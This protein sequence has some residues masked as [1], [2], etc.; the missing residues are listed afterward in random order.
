[1]LETLKVTMKSI[2]IKQTNKSPEINFNYD[3]GEL[4]IT[5][6]S[7]VQNSYEFYT[8]LLEWIDD[9]VRAPKAK[10]TKVFIKVVY[11]TTD[12]SGFFIKILKRLEQLAMANHLVMV[13]WYYE[14]GDVDMRETIHMFRSLVPQLNLESV[15]VKEVL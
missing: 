12:A 11:F 9:Y 10:N 6:N 4:K 5:G 15:V 13:K 14:E 7:L 1:M 8:P 3:T 2:F